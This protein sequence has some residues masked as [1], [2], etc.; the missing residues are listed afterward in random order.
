MEFGIAILRD[1]LYDEKKGGSDDGDLS[2]IFR[3]DFFF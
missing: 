1:L 2:R 3:Q